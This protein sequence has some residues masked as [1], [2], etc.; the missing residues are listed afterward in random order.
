MGS[1]EDDL[2]WNQ[3]Y[4]DASECEVHGDVQYYN[5]ESGEWECYDCAD[6]EDMANG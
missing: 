4:E 3:K 1:R 2:W 5:S 6:E